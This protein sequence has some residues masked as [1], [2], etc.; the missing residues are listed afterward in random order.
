MTGSPLTLTYLDRYV[1]IGLPSCVVAL[2][3]YRQTSCILFSPIFIFKHIA[4]KRD[5]STTA[6]PAVART[7]ILYLPERLHT[8]RIR[9][10]LHQ[11]YHRFIRGYTYTYTTVTR[12]TTMRKTNLAKILTEEEKTERNKKSQQP[13]PVCLPESRRRGVV[14]ASAA[15]SKRKR[16]Q[17]ATFKGGKRRVNES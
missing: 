5:Q 13:T 16:L 4:E 12:S 6:H 11:L 1:R 2:V 14:D 10:S 3:Q 8:C 7:G 9:T 15:R 17:R